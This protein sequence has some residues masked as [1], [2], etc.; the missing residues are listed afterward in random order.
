[1]NS[2]SGSSGSCSSKR[3]AGTPRLLLLLGLRGSGKSTV[4]RL[5]AQAQACSFTDLDDLTPGLLGCSSAREAFESKGEPAFR[6]AELQALQGVLGSR[7]G[8]VALGGGTPTAPGASEL[9]SQARARGEARAA[10]LRLT[11]AELRA[12]LEAGG[13]GAIATRPSLTGLGV[14]EEIEHV[15]RARDGLYRTLATREIPWRATPQE[16]VA[17]LMGWHG[18]DERG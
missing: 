15:F 10:Y 11:P 13:D 16:V 8:I 9:I 1:M 17:E 18:W 6:L 14:L 12:R 3:A 5:L 2:S 7:S 4:G